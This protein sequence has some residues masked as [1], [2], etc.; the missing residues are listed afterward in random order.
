MSAAY[1]FLDERSDIMKNM[2]KSAMEVIKKS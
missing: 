1:N 2:K